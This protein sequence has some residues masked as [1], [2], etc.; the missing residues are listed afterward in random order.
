MQRLSAD[1]TGKAQKYSRIGPREFVQVGTDELTIE[2]INTACIKHFASKIGSNLVCDVLAGEQGPSCSTIKQVRALKFIYVRFINEHSC[3]PRLNIG[4]ESFS[5]KVAQQIRASKRKYEDSVLQ[6]V[7]KPRPHSVPSPKKVATP[8]VPRSIS[9]TQMLKLGKVVKSTQVIDSF[10]F[11]L[12]RMTR[13]TVPKPIE[14]SVSNHLLGEGAFR[15][16]YTAETDHKEFSGVTWVIKEYKSRAVDIVGERTHKEGC[17]S[18]LPC[19][20]FCQPVQRSN[21]TSWI[22]RVFWKGI[23]IWQHISWQ[24]R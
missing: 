3:V 19:A 1:V 9:V 7:V 8:A 5:S 4:N 14:F 18:A 20:E 24:E 13:S 16:A 2:K 21:R 17:T 11:D 23:A 12:S 15:K 10:Q 6:S 22:A